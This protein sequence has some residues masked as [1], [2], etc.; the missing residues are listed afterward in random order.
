MAS[1][2]PK[3]TDQ[4]RTRVVAQ[5]SV[6]TRPRENA[7]IG[8]TQ[9]IMKQEGLFA[10]ISVP[11]VLASAAAA[12][13][14]ML[15]ASKIGIA[16]SVIGA[17]VSS[18]VTIVA[19][20]LYRRALTAGA[21]K[22]HTVSAGT[23][24]R[25]PQASSAAPASQNPYLRNSAQGARL[26][27]TKLQARAAAQRAA[28]QRKIAVASILVAA[29]TVGLVFAAIM[30]GTAGEG[31]GTKPAPLLAQ[32]EATQQASSDDQASIDFPAPDAAPKPSTPSMDAPT[33]PDDDSDQATE[34]APDAGTADGSADSAPQSGSS[35]TDTGSTDELP[36]SNAAADG[37]SDPSAQ[38]TDGGVTR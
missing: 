38:P 30:L 13:T 23:A 32:H 33:A 20:Q 31:L 29:L 22:L 26:A 3:Y 15:L 18:A 21:R 34:A 36:P 25:T 14:S 5:G 17:A 11:Q 27:P 35:A 24:D 12:A 7:S 4:Q 2:F 28:T 16:G 6:Y 19:T 8:S 37:S 10:G 9:P 1:E